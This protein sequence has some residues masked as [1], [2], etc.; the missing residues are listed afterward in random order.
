[1]E[2]VSNSFRNDL[3]CFFCYEVLGARKKCFSFII[4]TYSDLWN[5]SRRL[6]HSPVTPDFTEI[7]LVVKTID[8]ENSRL[9]LTCYRSSRTVHA[10]VVR[11][12]CYF[13]DGL[14]VREEDLV[15]DKRFFDEL[16]QRRGQLDLQLLKIKP[17]IN[18]SD[19]I[20]H[21]GFFVI[22]D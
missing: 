15:F 3:N 12:L 22:S 14:R 19:M 1:M 6:K 17:L 5:W 10:S 16:P 18:E 2:N 9:L 21:Q 7:E 4:F 13:G 11:D 8:R 20:R